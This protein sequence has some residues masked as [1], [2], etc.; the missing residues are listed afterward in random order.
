MAYSL[1]SVQR[2]AWVWK[3]VSSYDVAL[4][5]GNH[6][7]NVQLYDAT[8]FIAGIRFERN[9]S[10]QGSVPGHHGGRFWGRLAYDQFAPFVDILRNEAPVR[11]GYDDANPNQFKIQTG[12]EPTGDGELSG[13]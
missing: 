1:D 2:M 8:D 13:G 10:S 7:A 4:G 9:A 12:R 11:F 6:F 3:T 5:G